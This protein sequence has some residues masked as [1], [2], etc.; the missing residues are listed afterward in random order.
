MKRTRIRQI[1]RPRNCLCH[2]ARQYM[3]GSYRAGIGY[4]SRHPAIERLDLLKM[5]VA[6]T[7]AIH[8]AGNCYAKYR[9]LLLK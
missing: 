3:F 5:D 9:N 4:N 2:I 6:Y 1:T 7:F 8:Q